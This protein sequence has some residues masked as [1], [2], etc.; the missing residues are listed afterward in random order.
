MADAIVR[1]HGLESR[2]GKAGVTTGTEP[3]EGMLEITIMASVGQINLRGKPDEPAFLSAAEAALE[4]KLPL[5]PNT[6]TSGPQRVLWLGPNEWLVLV[7][8]DGGALA[9]KLATALDKTSAAVNDLSGGQT[10]LRIRG[11][12]V[13]DLLAAGC[14]LDFHP[15]VF[16]EGDCVQSGLAKANVIIC[17]VD[18]Q[19]TFEIIVRRSFSAYLLR[20]MTRMAPGRD[21]PVGVG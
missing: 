6:L 14:T 15:G 13:R 19:P 4:Q 3:G 21:C 7:E 9:A 16:G 12:A 5:E 17:Y 18:G 20:W 11:P 2:V 1:R 8:D 10:V